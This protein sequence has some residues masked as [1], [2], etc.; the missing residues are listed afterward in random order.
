[1]SRRQTVLPR[2]V[3][4]KIDS[5]HRAVFVPQAHMIEDI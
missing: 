1:M 2:L 5:L 4:T 3:A